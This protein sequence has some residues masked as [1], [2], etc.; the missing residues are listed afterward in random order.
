MQRTVS[1]PMLG[2]LVDGRYEVLARI[3]RGGMATVYRALDRRLDRTVALKAMHPHLA[4]SADFVARFRRE[5]RSA[6][7][8]NHPGIV[9]IYD[10]GLADDTSYLTM[11]LVEGHNLR[12]ELRRQGALPLGR[13]LDVVDGV[14]DALAC[15]H[16]AGV[17]HRDVKPENV[18]LER[19]GRPKVTDFGLARAV[20]EATAAS[21]GTVLG[22]VAYLAPEIVT[23]GIADARAD[24]YAAG[25]VLFELIT[26]AQPFVADQPIRVAFQHVND[27]VPRPSTRVEWLPAEVDELVAALTARDADDRPADADGALALLRRTR[28]ALDDATLA[29]RADVAPAV[30]EDGEATGGHPTDVTPLPAGT[31]ALPIGAIHAG[32]P[33]PGPVGPARRR[34]R[35]RAFALTMVLTLLAIAGG[36]SWWWF[37][38]GPGAYVTVPEV[39]GLP[40]DDAVAVLSE[41]GINLAVERE[42]HDT[43]PEHEVISAEPAPGDRVR[44][45]GTVVLHVSRGI[46]MVEVPELV[47]LTH[48]E[49]ATA[50][51]EAQLRVGQVETPYDDDAPEGEVMSAS[52]QA[53]EVIPYDQPVDLVVSAGREPVE[54]VSVVGAD[55]DTAVSD[56]ENAGLR[57]VVEEGYHPEVPA[58]RVVSQSPEPGEDVQLYRGDEV[59]VT[60]SLGPQPVELP[61]LIGR[62]VGAATD[63]LEAAGFVV[64]V[65]RVL[66]GIF[67]TVRS[68]SPAAGELAVPG[69]TVTL[70]VV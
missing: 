36:G 66:G 51:E 47:G 23:S 14:L 10:Q 30:E 28:A 11:E 41:A 33:D 69:T 2:R 62:Q 40:E 44:T 34:R 58:G 18:L 39:V 54:L 7:R 31:V 67:G 15:A 57:A 65:K 50:L 42:H 22:T 25:I 20:T 38:H 63:E 1:D 37:T 9:A 4:E 43:A 55:T 48:E 24:V 56:L 5:A 27:G 8:L 29:R 46:L 6:A 3:A 68:M 19:D 17:V 61:D 60:V 52:Q 13:A 45:D 49:A 16:R 32:T 35:R 59:S 26:G 64:E 70:T 12:T 53:G 21:T